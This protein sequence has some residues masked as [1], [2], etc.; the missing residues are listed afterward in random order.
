MGNPLSHRGKIREQEELRDA[1][2][3][4]YEDRSHTAK[5]ASRSA[6]AAY[7]DWVSAKCHITELEHQRDKRVQRLIVQVGQ[8]IVYYMHTQGTRNHERKIT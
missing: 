1:A 6:S 4:R 5:M 3:R 2:W 7:R 8:V